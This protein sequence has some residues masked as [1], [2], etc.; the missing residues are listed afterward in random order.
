[1]S[2]KILITGAN[3]FLGSAI[4]KLALNKGYK[5][6]VLVRKN[7]NLDNLMKFKSKI[8]FFYGD[9][10]DKDDLYEPVKESD[11]IF[12][13]AADYRLWSR[14]PSEIYDT[15]VHGTENIALLALK[16]KKKL[17]YTS[18]VA[19]LG[20][21]KDGGNETTEVEFDQMIGDYKKSKYL[22]EKII[23]KLV[24]KDLK[25]I[26]VNPSTP[27]GPGDIKPTP[28]GKI[29]LDVL[30]GKM[31][32]YV[33]TGLNFVHVDDVAEGH[34]LA[35]EKGKI[36]EK[37][38]LGGENLNFKDF[39]DMVSE[40]GNVPKVN[41]QINFKYLIP[42]AFLNEFL[43]KFFISRNP[44]LTIDSLKMSSKKMFFSSMK[45]KKKLGYRPRPAKNAIKDAINWMNNYFK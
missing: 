23:E 17:V 30:K 39:L 40:I 14:K 44:S 4:T 37:Y 2:K 12:H 9:L 33:D 26:I 45:A 11:I 13:V 28:T 6:S 24:K 27:I 21:D 20:L 8:N 5:V 36:G 41:F 19:A 32:A 1:M 7:S 10:R 22:A 35:L 29:I 3:G 31:P 18:S 16:L 34:F 43:C 25:V 42:L 15:N 38:I